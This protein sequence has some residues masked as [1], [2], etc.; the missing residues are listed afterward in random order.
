MLQVHI[1][2]CI[3][4]IIQLAIDWIKEGLKK[5]NLGPKGCTR[6]QQIQP[7]NIQSKIYNSTLS[8]KLQKKCSRI[9]TY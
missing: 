3:Q 4:L 7:I 2:D 5:H 8:S 9:I 6:R 1:I